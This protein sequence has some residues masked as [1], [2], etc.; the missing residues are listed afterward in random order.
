MIMI[1]TQDGKVDIKDPSVKRLVQSFGQDLLY[2][3]SKG[4]QKVPKHVTLPLTVKNL[5][6][7]KEV[8]ID[9][10]MGYPTIKFFK[11]RQHWQRSN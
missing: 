2:A 1:I 7:S 6:G 11:L 3:V 8:I 4:R 10:V 5:T 9:M